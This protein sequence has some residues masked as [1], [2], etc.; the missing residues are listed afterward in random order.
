[1][2]TCIELD[3]AVSADGNV[4]QK[5]AER[6]LNTRVNYRDTRNV[7]HEMH[8]YTFNNYYRYYNWSH[9]NNNRS[10][11]EQFGSHGR[12]TFSRFAEKRQV[13]FEHHTS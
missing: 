10:L 6:K 4:M 11:E 7:E 1:M 3:V 5:E 13:C 12:K 9:R 2:N 8:D